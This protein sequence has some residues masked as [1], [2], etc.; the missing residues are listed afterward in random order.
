VKVD[1]AKRRQRHTWRKW[2]KRMEIDMPIHDIISEHDGI[3]LVGQNGERIK[4][5]LNEQE[6]ELLKERLGEKV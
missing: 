4:V 1:A 6:R 2:R 5:L 3:T